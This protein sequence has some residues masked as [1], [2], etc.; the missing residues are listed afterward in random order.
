MPVTSASFLYLAYKHNKYPE[1]A[2][3]IVEGWNLNLRWRCVV[4]LGKRAMGTPGWSVNSAQGHGECQ[5][6]KDS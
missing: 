6:R 1:V 3:N 2:N 5:T 4:V